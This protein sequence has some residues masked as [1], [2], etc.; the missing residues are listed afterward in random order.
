MSVVGSR[1]GWCRFENSCEWDGVAPSWEAVHSRSC[2]RQWLLAARNMSSRSSPVAVSQTAF[3]TP[4]F[5]V[6]S[7]HC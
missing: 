6:I 2:S 4:P 1:A 5:F 3:T 7:T